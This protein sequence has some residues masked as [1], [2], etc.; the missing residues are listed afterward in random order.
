MDWIW[1]WIRPA[2]S[3]LWDRLAAAALIQAL[4]WELPYATGADIKRKTNK[5]K[6]NIPKRITKPR[7]YTK[8]MLI[9][10]SLLTKTA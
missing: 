5:N 4:A 8:I 7:V 9:M 1:L 3:W 6:E 2:L 10:Y